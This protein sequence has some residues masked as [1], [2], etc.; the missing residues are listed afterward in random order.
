MQPF[1]FQ[2]VKA[3]SFVVMVLRKFRAST[4]LE[5]SNQH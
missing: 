4:P 1:A 3:K 2:N 5:R